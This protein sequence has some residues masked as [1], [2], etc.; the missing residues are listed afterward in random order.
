MINRNTPKEFLKVNEE[1]IVDIFDVIIY[2]PTPA[3][4]L[5]QWIS[6]F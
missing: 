4:T 6:L 2:A 5:I 1:R 3:L